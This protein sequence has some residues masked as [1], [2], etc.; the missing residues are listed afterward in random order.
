M[1]DEI[2]SIDSLETISEPV[3]LGSLHGSPE[4]H[5]TLLEDHSSGCVCS[6]GNIC[7]P[8]V[9]GDEVLGAFWALARSLLHVLKEHDLG[10]ESDI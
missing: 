1:K 4:A 7:C 6:T 5:N 10:G 3:N 9:A 8:S 2:I